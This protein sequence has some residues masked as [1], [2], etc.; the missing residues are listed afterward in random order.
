MAADHGS[1]V[2]DQEPKLLTELFLS[3]WRDRLVRGGEEATS[4][5]LGCKPVC[6]G[7]PH[8]ERN[9]VLFD[10]LRRELFA[11]LVERLDG[12]RGERGEMGEVSGADR[13]GDEMATWQVR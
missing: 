1:L 5:D 3:G 8:G 12:L 9:E 13:H 6:F 11:N 2:V 10:L 4:G 7:E